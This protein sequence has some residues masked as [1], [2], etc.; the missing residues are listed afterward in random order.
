MKARKVMIAWDEIGPVPPGGRRLKVGP[1][2]DVTGW[3]EPYSSTDGACFT[4]WRQCSAEELITRV[5]VLFSLL[6][7]RVKFDPAVVHNEF[8]AIDEYRD[9]LPEESQRPIPIHGS[10]RPDDH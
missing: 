7:T 9:A 2:P 5:F 6:V 1:F 3:S 8:L 4:V 10:T